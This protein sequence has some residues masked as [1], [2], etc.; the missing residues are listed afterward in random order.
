MAILSGEVKQVK[1][2][3]DR[4]FI[5]NLMPASF[6]PIDIYFTEEMNAVQQ[7]QLLC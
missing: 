5:K 6:E 4:T 1:W 3:I 7:N 2:N